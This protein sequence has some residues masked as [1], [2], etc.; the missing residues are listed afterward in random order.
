MHALV[1][2]V[3]KIANRVT[4]NKKMDDRVKNGKQLNVEVLARLE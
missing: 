2:V 4:T 1:C 3:K